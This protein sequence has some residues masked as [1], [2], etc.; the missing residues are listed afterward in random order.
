LSAHSNRAIVIEHDG[1]SAGCA[2]I[3]REEVRHAGIL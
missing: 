3:E 2:L 1:A